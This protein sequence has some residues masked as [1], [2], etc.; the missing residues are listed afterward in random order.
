[1]ILEILWAG[2]LYVLE[3]EE[4]IELDPAEVGKIKETREITDHD[5][6]I[7]IED[8][9]NDSEPKAKR[10]KLEIPG[11]GANVVAN[12]DTNTEEGREE[13]ASHSYLHAEVHE[14]NMKEIVTSDVLFEK[15]R[16]DDSPKGRITEVPEIDSNS[17]DQEKEQDKERIRETE[18]NAKITDLTE[19]L[20]T[21]VS[22]TTE[23]ME[24]AVQ[25]LDI[26]EMSEDNIL[27]ACGHLTAVSELIS[28]SNCVCFLKFVLCDTVMSLTQKASRVL[29]S[30]V[31]MVADKY[32]KQLTDSVLMPC[33]KGTFDTPQLDLMTIILKEQFSDGNQHYFL[34]SIV[35]GEL[36][37]N[38][39]KITLLQTLIDITNTDNDILR[40][41]FFLF[42]TQSS[43]LAKNLKFGK[44]LLA[45]ANK[46]G[47]VLSGENLTT[48]SNIVDKHQTFLKKS[49]QNVIK[50]LR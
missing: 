32:P 47:R 19:V 46:Y 16:V 34:R 41:L 13:V 42:E 29:A 5:D 14:T 48:F 6:I 49:V 12:L 25:E 43:N 3:M 1:M 39:S 9:S 2:C 38:D 37:L 31:N 35:E 24:N 18:H 21:L 8:D 22:M 15:T 30:A 26:G 36:E 11:D 44:L 17:L 23:E 33:V 20:K 45:V 10:R 28:Y 40:K 27:A 50:K 4:V 7:C